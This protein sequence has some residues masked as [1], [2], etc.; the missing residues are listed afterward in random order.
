MWA[1]LHS[2]CLISIVLS[3]MIYTQS[4]LS[5][6]VN[7]G[8]VYTQSKQSEDTLFFFPCRVS[9]SNGLAARDEMSLQDVVLACILLS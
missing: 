4:K 3:T 2:I 6:V 7:Y 9:V 8:L 5:I 1:S